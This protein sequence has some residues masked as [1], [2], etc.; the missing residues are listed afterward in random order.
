[1]GPSGVFDQSLERITLAISL[2]PSHSKEEPAGANLM[3][4]L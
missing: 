3:R 4:G 2:P 1:M